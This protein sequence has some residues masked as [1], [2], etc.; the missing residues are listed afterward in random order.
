MQNVTLRLACVGLAGLV[1]ATCMH[2]ANADIRVF[3][4]GGL[5]SM[6]PQDSEK[7]SDKA[8]TG[9]E[10][11]V[12]GH[13]DIL[14]PAPG[15]AVYAGPELR[16]GTLTREYTANNSLTK[17]TLKSK[18][19]GLEAGVHVGI[20]P[21]VTLQ[22]GLNYSFPTGGNVEFES[23]LVGKASFDASKGSETGVT[24][25][26]LITPFPLTRLGLEYSLGSGNVKYSDLSDELKYDFWAARAV[27]GIAL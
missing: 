17:E 5:V 23:P 2:S 16:M 1:S 8:L 10:G 19:A 3:A 21:I 26:G 7:T 13:F 24:L 11:K 12:A 6:T 25:R 15:I 20:I 14:S 9:I 18:S 22:A 27:F 4:A